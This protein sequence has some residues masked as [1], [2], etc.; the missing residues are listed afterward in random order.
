MAAGTFP[1]CGGSEEL[2]SVSLGMVP[3]RLRVAALGHA[4]E[5]RAKAAIASRIAAR[6]QSWAAGQAD[7]MEILM[8]RT[9]KRTIAPIL[10]S[11]RRMVPQVALAK[12]VSCRPIRRKAQSNT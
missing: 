2:I 8:R 3:H 4:G 7:A 10:S 6:A 12:S 9:L 11:L 1:C 5:A